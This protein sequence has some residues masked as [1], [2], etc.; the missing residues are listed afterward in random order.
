M[1]SS[2]EV[3]VTPNEGTAVTAAKPEPTTELTKYERLAA[4]FDEVHERSIGGQLFTYITKE[5]SLS[6]ANEVLGIAGW[7]YTVQ[8]SEINAEANSV[9]VHVRVSVYDEGAGPTTSRDGFGSAEIKRRRSDG[10]IMNL[11]NDYKSA[12]TQAVKVALASYGIGL[13]LYEKDDGIPDNDSDEGTTAAPAA[14]RAAAPRPVTASA[15]SGNLDC[16]ECG[17][18]IKPVTFKPK[19][20]QEI[21]DTWSPQKIAKWSTETKGGQKC[22][23]CASGRGNGKAAPAKAASSDLPF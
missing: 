16:G 9:V 4:R 12:C 1:M 19:P 17:E 15:P 23:N 22:M 8:H 11:G 18:Q 13:Y 7:G 5:Q 2:Y 14:K 21:G 6:R 20:G 10:Q 3:R